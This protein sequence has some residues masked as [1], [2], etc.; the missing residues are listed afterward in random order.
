[1]NVRLAGSSRKADIV[2]RIIGMARI[3]AIRD[4][5]LDEESDLCGI[6]YVYNQ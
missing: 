5:T 6:S 2:D 3:G 4:D 1:M